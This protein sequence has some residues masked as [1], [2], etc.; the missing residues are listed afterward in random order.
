MAWKPRGALAVRSPQRHGQ[1]K[2]FAAAHP[3]PAR[4]GDNLINR[5]LYV[6]VVLPEQFNV[7]GLREVRDEKG[8]SVAHEL[9]ERYGGPVVIAGR[10]EG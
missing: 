4:I 1:T 6:P 10:D 9:F 8:A 3:K 5:R 7:V 2:L